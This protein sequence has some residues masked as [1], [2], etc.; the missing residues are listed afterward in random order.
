[1]KKCTKCGQEKE[2]SE[3]LFT[4]RDGIEAQCK[5]CKYEHVRNWKRNNRDKCNASQKEWIKNNPEKYLEMQR[6]TYH[7]HIEKR[8]KYSRELRKRLRKERGYDGEDIRRNGEMAKQLQGKKCE[9]CESINNLCIHHKDNNGRNALNKK[10]RP[11][12]N[13]DNLIVLCQS[14]HG[15]LHY[16]LRK[17]DNYGRFK[18]EKK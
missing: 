7:K 18:K 17:I 10:L 2:L 5:K 9:L 6:K 13:P 15:K 4:K 1:M 3:F 14:C 16:S 11:N 8:R 12:N